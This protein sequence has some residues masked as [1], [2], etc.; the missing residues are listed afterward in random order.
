M[1]QW[2]KNLRTEKKLTMKELATKLGISE[3]Y[4]CAIENGDRQ[5]NMDITLVAALSAAL[6]VSI[7]AIAQY[8]SDVQAATRSASM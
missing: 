3:S 5:K 7:S 6:G 1:R 8:E 4:Y 2:L